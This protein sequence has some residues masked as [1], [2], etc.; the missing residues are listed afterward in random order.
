[1]NCPVT[2]HSLLAAIHWFKRPHPHG[3][4]FLRCH[5]PLFVLRVWRAPTSLTA[6][7]S[8]A[9]PPLSFLFPFPALPLSSWCVSLLACSFC[10][11]PCPPLSFSCLLCRCP[12]LL[13]CYSPWFSCLCLSLPLPTDKWSP[14]EHDAMGGRQLE[15]TSWSPAGFNARSK[16]VYRW[17]Y[18]SGPRA[19]TPWI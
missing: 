13:S 3:D 15:T 16:W 5:T 9:Y 4:P 6:D 7:V 19:S 1:M 11:S 10:F 14:R 17:W 8:G 18:Q 2:I 12:L